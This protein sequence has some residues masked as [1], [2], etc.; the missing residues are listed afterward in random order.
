ME[1]LTESAIR[2]SFIN[3]TRSE[4]SALNLPA[5]F[6]ELD[7][8]NLDY[9]GWRDPK[10][11][12]RGYLVTPLAGRPVG[13]LLRAPETSTPG[14]KRVLCA[15]CQ[16]VHSEEDVYLY[17][18]RR[19]GQPGRDGNTVGTLICAD[20]FCSANVRLQ[21]PATPIHPDPEVVTAGRIAGLRQR[22]ALFLQRVL[23]K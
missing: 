18:A 6:A 8:D 13:V 20:F 1:Q 12:Q 5:G 9:L 17:V 19:A 3:A 11:P 14:N 21:V 23:G 10:M 7:W 15:L 2:K 16:D 4:V 22:T